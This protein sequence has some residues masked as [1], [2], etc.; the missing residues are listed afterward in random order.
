MKTIIDENREI[1][2][3][4]NEVL[5]ETKYRAIF[6]DIYCSSC[7]RVV[8]DISLP[9]SKISL[10]LSEISFTLSD[11]SLLFSEISLSLDE[12]LLQLNELLLPLSEKL[13]NMGCD[14]FIF[15]SDRSDQEKRS[16]SK[17][18]LVFS[19]LF[20]L[21]RTDPLSF[22]PKFPEILVKWIAPKVSYVSKLLGV[23]CIRHANSCVEI[24][25]F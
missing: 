14:P 13:M 2:A 19:K 15:R 16:I 9:E 12:K 24:Y 4:F 11:I 22:G 21:D 8:S 10:P 20:R 1:S 3:N 5:F 6:R 23:Q 18:G 7:R 25:S 17:G